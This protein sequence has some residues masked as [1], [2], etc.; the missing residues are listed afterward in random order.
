[1][2]PH[3]LSLL[4]LWTVAGLINVV[5]CSRDDK[6]SANLYQI[7]DSEGK[8]LLCIVQPPGALCWAD[9]C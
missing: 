3:T 8:T 6:D 7:V 4:H 2:L 5:C 9:L 1:M